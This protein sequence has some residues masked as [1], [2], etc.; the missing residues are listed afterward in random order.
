VVVPYA[1]F[2][3]GRIAQEIFDSLN[4]VQIGGPQID[5]DRRTQ[6]RWL[7][8]GLVSAVI[9]LGSMAV[10]APQAG[11]CFTVPTGVRKVNLFVA[12]D[13]RI[14]SDSLL[15]AYVQPPFQLSVPPG[16]QWHYVPTYMWSDMRWICSG[17]FID[18]V[19]IEEQFLHGR[20]PLSWRTRELRML[21]TFRGEPV[22]AQFSNRFYASQWYLVESNFDDGQLAFMLRRAADLEDPMWRLHYVAGLAGDTLP[23]GVSADTLETA[24]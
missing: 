23:A 9:I 10:R 24:P 21:G 18:E 8:A 11:T 19:I 15:G 13:P 1:V 3:F 5:L 4:S 6:S 7:T 2:L 16:H 12:N 20:V 14:A 22:V 17:D